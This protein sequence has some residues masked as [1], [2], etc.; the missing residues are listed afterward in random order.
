MA[1]RVEQDLDLDVAGALEQALEDEPIVAERGDGFAPCGGQRLGQPARLTDRAHPLAAAAGRRLDDEREAD[2]AC[3]PGQD[4]VGLSGAVVAGQD[5]DAERGGQPTRGGLVAHRADGRRWWPDPADPGGL[6]S[7]GEL[8]VLGEEPEA[9]MEGVGAG[10]QGCCHDGRRDPAGRGRRAVRD[11]DDRPD[12]EPIAGAG[13]PPGDLASVGDEDGSD[14]R[15]GARPLVGPRRGG[16]NASIASEATRHR[17]P[18]RRAGSRPLAIQRW[19]DRGD[20]PSRSRP[21]VGSARL[22][23]CR[24]CRTCPDGAPAVSGVNRRRSRP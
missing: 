22:A 5:R 15:S 4:A 7:L 17:P 18:T 23:S 19:T 3:R 11:R 14:R 9:R 24:E 16:A 12:P 10:G 8:G 6:D 1:V 13:D 21:R 2:P 20:V